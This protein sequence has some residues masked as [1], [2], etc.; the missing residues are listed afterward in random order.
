MIFVGERSLRRTITEFVTHYHHERNYQGL[1]N[2]LIFP[3]GVRR[4]SD[5][6]V[7]GVSGNHR[8]LLLRKGKKR[9]TFPVS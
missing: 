6:R 5:D 1:G 8:S 3:G 9:A 7:D 2:V 4:R